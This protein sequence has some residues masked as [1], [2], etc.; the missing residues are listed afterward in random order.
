MVSASEF[1][2]EDL[3]FDTLV[4]AEGGGGGLPLRRDNSCAG[5]FVPDPPSCVRHTPKFA[6]TP[7]IPYPCVVNSRPQ[8]RWYGHT[9]ILHELGE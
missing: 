9:K 5:L 7:K 2:S 1:K 8:S 6:L 3:G 4:G